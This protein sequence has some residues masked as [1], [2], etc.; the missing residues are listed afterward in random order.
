MLPVGSRPAAASVA[1]NYSD[2]DE[3]IFD[4]TRPLVFNTI[5]DLGVAR[6][7]FSTMRQ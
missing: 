6:P 1:G 2:H 7:H 3:A 5:P 4:A